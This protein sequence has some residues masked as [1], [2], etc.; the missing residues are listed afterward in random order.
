MDKGQHVFFGQF[1]RVHPCLRIVNYDPVHPG[2][3]E[4]LWVADAGDED[5]DSES[6]SCCEPTPPPRCSFKTAWIFFWY[7]IVLNKIVTNPQCE[8]DGT[9]WKGEAEL[10][11]M[12]YVDSLVILL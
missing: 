7:K 12:L 5:K 8:D 11:G 4:T 10:D 9:Y 3:E 2:P 1:L 6:H